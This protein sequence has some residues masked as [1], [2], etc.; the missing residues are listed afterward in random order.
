MK[1]IAAEVY[2]N[3]DDENHCATVGFRAATDEYLLI[4]RDLEP[5]EQDRRLRLNGIHVELTDQGYSCYDGI[6]SVTML[7]SAIRFDLNEKGRHNL[8]QD[9]VEVVHDLRQVQLF[10]LRQVLALVFEG[11]PRYTDCV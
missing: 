11:F 8:Q 5:T 6:A 7:P 9:F 10:Q 2:F 1:L 3:P 4:S